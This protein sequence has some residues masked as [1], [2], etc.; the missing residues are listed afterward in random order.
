VRRRSWENLSLG[1]KG[2]AV[3]AIPLASL[4]VAVA[5]SYYVTIQSVTDELYVTRYLQRVQTSTQKIQNVMQGAEAGVRGYL[6]TGINSTLR[7]FRQAQRFL[8]RQLEDLQELQALAKEDDLGFSDPDAKGARALMIALP[9]LNDLPSELGD[10][11]GLVEE[12]LDVLDGVVEAA[13]K[14][15]QPG[16][17]EEQIATIPDL[18]ERLLGRAELIQNLNE[19]L[20]PAEVQLFKLPEIASEKAADRRASQLKII[21][22]IAALGLVGGLLAL[23]LYTRTITRRIAAL[24]QGARRMAVGEPTGDL[25]GGRDAIGRLATE[26]DRTSQL[27]TER[28]AGLLAARNEAD[29]ANQAKSEFLSRMSHELRTPLNAILG[30]GQLLQIDGLDPKHREDVDQIVK[31]GR[32]LLDLINEVLDIARVEAGRLSL[33]LEPVSVDDA[34]RESVDLIQPLA[35][36][37]KLSLSVSTDEAGLYVRADRQRLKQVLLNLLSNAVKYNVEGGS[38]EL[39]AREGSRGTVVLTVQDTGVGIPPH[40]VDQLFAPFDRLGADRQGVTGTGLG[41]SLSKALVEAMDGSISVTTDVGKGSTFEVSLPRAQER[42]TRPSADAAPAPLPAVD[43]SKRSLLYIEDNVSNLRL[44]ENMLRLR[45]SYKITG[46]EQGTL[47]L[48]LAAGTW[49]DAILLDLDLPDMP[50]SEVLRMLKAAP[51]T[52]DIPVIIVTADATPGQK[53]RL[54]SEGAAAYV[55]K[56]FDV[57]ALLTAIDQALGQ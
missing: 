27:L 13:G 48:D 49:P 43:R 1:G 28:A 30:F 11:R 55:T 29:R 21:V 47:G 22:L 20:Q 42:P 12:R 33:S 23:L 4:V 3:V 51:A 37:R 45:P 17:F 40:K 25:P 38:V 36:E 44:V 39:G 14:D 16:D 41:L 24:E 10:I 34:I 5:L 31:A 54:M 52:Q 6:L 35:V 18:H 19:V 53:Q 56:P 15:F 26:I 46:A 32:H 2:L 8:P 50:G 7:R 9:G 57:A